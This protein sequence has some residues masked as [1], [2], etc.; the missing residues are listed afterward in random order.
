MRNYPRTSHHLLGYRHRQ[1]QWAHSLYCGQLDAQ[2]DSYLLHLFQYRGFSLSG[3]A[4][5][6]SPATNVRRGLVA[7]SFVLLAPLVSSPC[8]DADG[9]IDLLAV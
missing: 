2:L 5:G 3:S 9:G 7:P 8:L 4:T 6:H 1:G